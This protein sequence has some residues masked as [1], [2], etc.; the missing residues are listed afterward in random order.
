[1]NIQPNIF[2]CELLVRFNAEKLQGAHAIDMQQLVD[3]DEPVDS[4]TRVVQEK[5]MDPRP[6]TIEEAKALLGT[7]STK[8]LAEVGVLRTENEGL[9]A[10]SAKLAAIITI[11]TAP[12]QPTGT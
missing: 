7:D 12:T 6:I 4:P 3:L 2:L 9:K 10:D 8:M 11:L 5:M 1:M